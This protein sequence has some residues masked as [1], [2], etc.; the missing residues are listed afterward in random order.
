MKRSRLLHLTVLYAKAILRRQNRGR[1][2]GVAIQ[3]IDDLPLTIDDS[4]YRR[5]TPRGCGAGAEP[6]FEAMRQV[7]YEAVPAPAPYGA[8]RQGDSAEAESGK[9]AWRGGF[10]WAWK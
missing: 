1:T 8:I 3:N 9:D 6:N 7:G 4:L 10:M 2:R 5:L